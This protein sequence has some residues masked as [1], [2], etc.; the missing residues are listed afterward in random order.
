MVSHLSGTCAMG[1]VV[2]TVCKVKGVENLRVVDA[3]VFPFPLGS[4]YQATVYAVAEQ[5]SVLLTLGNLKS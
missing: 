3:S 1:M 4:H 5:V 2:G